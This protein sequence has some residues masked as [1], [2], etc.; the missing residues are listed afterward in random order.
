MSLLVLPAH[1]SAPRGS[2]NVSFAPSACGAMISIS[3]FRNHCQPC[4]SAPCPAH[5]GARSGAPS[6][7]PADRTHRARNARQG[8]RSD[9][10][11]AFHQRAWMRAMPTRSSRTRK[12]AHASATAGS[13][14]RSRFPCLISARRVFGRP[15]KPICRQSTGSLKK[16]STCARKRAKRIVTIATSYDIASHYQR[17]VLPLRKI[18]SDELMLRYGAM[19]I[20]VFTLLPRR[21][22]NSPSTRRRSM[23][24]AI[25]GSQAQICRRS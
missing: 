11:H 15:N 3:L 5:G 13:R 8:L 22:R 14:C 1:S 19:Q 9:Q 24:C 16:R 20:D 21:S 17:D 12:R 25:S 4:R 7:R 23:R 6:R 10:R 2:V 18:I